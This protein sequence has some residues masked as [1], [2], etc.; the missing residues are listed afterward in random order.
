MC[1]SLSSVGRASSSYGV[2]PGIVPK[3]WKSTISGVSPGKRTP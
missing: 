1:T 3:Y 2:M